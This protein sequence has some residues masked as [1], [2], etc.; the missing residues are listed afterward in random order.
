MHVCVGLAALRTNKLDYHSQFSI[1]IT[2]NSMYLQELSQIINIKI[3]YVVG[4][5]SNVISVNDEITSKY[6]QL[7]L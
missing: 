1:N 2:L 7:R 4:T 3:D 5:R 6:E